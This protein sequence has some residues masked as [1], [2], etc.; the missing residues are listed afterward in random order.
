MFESKSQWNY[1]NTLLLLNGSTML[2]EQFFNSQMI[3]LRHKWVDL[4]KSFD[5]TKK[6]SGHG[7][8]FKIVIIGNKIVLLWHFISQRTV[9]F[10]MT[11]VNLHRQIHIK[12]WM[13][14]SNYARITFELG[15]KESQITQLCINEF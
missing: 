5:I 14:S 12:I 3:I 6:L 9:I 4:N 15:C 13:K 8:S 11:C 7:L 1:N 2:N 10:P